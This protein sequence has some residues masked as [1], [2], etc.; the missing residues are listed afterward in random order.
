VAE[1]SAIAG[2]AIEARTAVNIM[3]AGAD[4]ILWVR[5]RARE[6]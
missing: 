6:K 4:E 3:P 1:E 2:R 5:I